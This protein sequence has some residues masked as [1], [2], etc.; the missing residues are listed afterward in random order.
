MTQITELYDKT[1]KNLAEAVTFGVY[2]IE[3][4]LQ[5][6]IDQLKAE[7]EKMAIKHEAQIESLK[8]MH[9]SSIVL[10]Q[11]SAAKAINQAEGTASQVNFDY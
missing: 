8:K 5:Q 4:S 6:E 3:E 10:I 9:A 1:E 2:A 7:S 11:E